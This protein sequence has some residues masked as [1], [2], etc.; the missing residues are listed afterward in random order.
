MQA[1]SFHLSQF[2]T[3]CLV[4]EGRTNRDIEVDGCPCH[5]FPSAQQ[6]SSWPKGS[7]RVSMIN[8]VDLAG[9]EKAIY[10][11]GT[12][13]D[14]CCEMWNMA[15]ALM[16]N[17]ELNSVKPAMTMSYMSR[18]DL[19]VRWSRP[20]LRE[21]AWR[22]VRWSIN[23]CSSDQVGQHLDP[24]NYSDWWSLLL[25][26]K[27]HLGKLHRK[28]GREIDKSKEGG[29]NSVWL[30]LAMI[31]WCTF[32]VQIWKFWTAEKQTATS[33]CVRNSRQAV[34]VPYRE[35]KLTRLLQN[36]LGRNNMEQRFA[37]EAS[38]FS[39]HKI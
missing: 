2:V 29:R 26:A 31:V 32:A 19:T 8:L 34:L 36:A 3:S 15:V 18:H 39:A 12:S 1:F 17:D 37:W 13:W 7:T 6:V 14:F 25:D 16:L 20:G 4:P 27:E 9:S 10:A 21:N 24:M 38:A 35:S 30:C 22:K 5:D 28:A 23:L 11:I 33:V